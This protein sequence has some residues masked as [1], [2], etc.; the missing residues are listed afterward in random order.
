MSKKEKKEMRAGKKG[1]QEAE[2]GKN[3]NRKQIRE[4]KEI[5]RAQ[6]IFKEGRQTRDYK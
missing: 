4:K 2:Q 1:K 3:V 5:M 6:K